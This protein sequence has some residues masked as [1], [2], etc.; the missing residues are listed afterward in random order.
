MRRVLLTLLLLL[1]TVSAVSAQARA[2]LDVRLGPDPR[3]GPDPE[4]RVANLFDEAQWREALDNAYSIRLAWRVQSWRKRTLIDAIGAQQEWQVI[5]MRQPLMEEYQ[6][7]TQAPGGRPIEQRFGTLDSLKVAL[8]GYS[9]LR[10]LRPRTDGEWYY[11]AR[12][13]IS[14]L[15]DEELTQLQQFMSSSGREAAQD[16]GGRLQRFLMRL[17]LPEGQILT[18]RTQSFRVGPP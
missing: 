10:S 11:A 17:G 4:F 6:M 2:R 5:V 13:E 18:A 1:G 9:T 3:N 16:G 8:S 12:V 15:N 14:T 7:V